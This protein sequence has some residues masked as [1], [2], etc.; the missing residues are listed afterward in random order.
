MTDSA[1]WLKAITPLRPELSFLRVLLFA[2]VLLVGCAPA[3]P[4]VDPPTPPVSRAKPTE[5]PQDTAPPE[6]LV[7]VRPP[8]VLKPLPTTAQVQDSV[9]RGRVDP[10]APVRGPQA[11]PGTGGGSGASG[12]GAISL[13]GVM[14]VG[15]QLQALVRTSVGSGA[16]CVGPEGRCGGT[17]GEALLPKEWTVRS[18]DLQR[19]CLTY[20]VEGKGQELVC[21]EDD[22][23]VDA[24]VKV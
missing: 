8:D 6:P 21:M 1:I 10:F 18:I 2:P 14:A 3:D 13:Q 12:G 15:S 9:S 7:P 19:G 11:G 22:E 4:P 24:E 5:A 20:T 23:E 17:A 16:I